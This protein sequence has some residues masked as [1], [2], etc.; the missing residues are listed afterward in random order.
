VNGKVCAFKD[1]AKLLKSKGIDL[2]NNRFLILQVC[3]CVCVCV[4]VC[5][6]A[7][8]I[9]VIKYMCVF[10]CVCVYACMYVR[11]V[12]MNVCMYV[13]TYVCVCFDV[14]YIITSYNIG[15][16]THTSVMKNVCIGRS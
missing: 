11:Y 16:Y 13:C 9:G 6:Y 7:C 3:V 4:Y 15:K 1:I 2:N 14:V 10:V 5:M 12:C 8:M